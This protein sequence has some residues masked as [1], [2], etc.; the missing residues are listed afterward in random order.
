[1]SRR[2][3]LEDLFRRSR[4]GGVTPNDVSRSTSFA[5]V[6]RHPGNVTRPT[7]TL[8]ADEVSDGGRQVSS[9]SSAVWLTL[10]NSLRLNLLLGRIFAEVVF[11]DCNP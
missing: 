4:P 11:G 6:V 2:C 7:E 5:V 8:V 10:L 1:M 9:L 3:T